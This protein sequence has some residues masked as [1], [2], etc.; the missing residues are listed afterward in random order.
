MNI[1]YFI[2]SA[3]P[4]KGGSA[5]HMA[6]VQL[7]KDGKID[8]NA[9]DLAFK[10]GIVPTIAPSIV[11]NRSMVTSSPDHRELVQLLNSG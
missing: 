10:N 11:K 1:D 9:F 4:M 2:K 6:L 3:A 5:D 8:Q 7:L